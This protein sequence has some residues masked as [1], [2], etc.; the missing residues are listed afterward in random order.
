MGPDEPCEMS[1]LHQKAAGL[2]QGDLWLSGPPS[3]LPGF[4]AEAP[5]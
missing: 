5:N 2:V 3:S 4:A 1:P